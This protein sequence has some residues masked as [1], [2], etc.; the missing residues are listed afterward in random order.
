MS[1]SARLLLE[2]AG[3]RLPSPNGV[4]LAIMDLWEDERATVRQMAQLVQSDPGL[5]GRLL[6]LAN[7]AAM[8]GRS[9]AAIP[10][11]IVRVGMQTVGQLAV[12]FS[13]IDSHG[14]GFCASFKYQEYWSHCLLMA[15]LSRELAQAT[16]IGPPEDLFACG[17]LSRIG[18]LAFATIYPDE[19]GQLLSEKPDEL[20]EAERQRFGVDHNE[21]SEV[22]MLDYG[23]PQAL[24]EPARFHEAP[25]TSEFA[26][27]SRPAKLATLLH[28]AHRM[29]AI[30]VESGQDRTRQTILNK[31]LIAKLGLDEQAIGSLYDRATKEW[32][33]W[34]KLLDL[35][36]SEAP[37]YAELV[38]S[39]SDLDTTISAPAR[40]LAFI[41]DGQQ[42]PSGIAEHLRQLA[43][44]VS[45]CSDTNE[46]L[47]QVVGARPQILVIPADEEGRKLCRLIRSTD[48][49]RSPYIFMVSPGNE[50]QLVIE[51]FDTGA[52]ALISPNI[53]RT[54]LE[55]RLMAVRRVYG[56]E[57]AWRKDRAELRKIANELA[58][59]HRKQ[60]LLSLT[61]Q[62]TELP[63]RRA[64]MLALEQAWA[65]STR[66]KSPVSVVI[67]DVDHFKAIND[68]FGHATGD[69]VLQQVATVL[70]AAARQEETI[71]R[72]GG[73]EFLLISGNAGLREL[74]IAAER[75][76]RQIQSTPLKAND[77]SI[78]LTMSM[79]IAERETTTI[80]PDELLNAAD[81]ALYAAKSAGRNRLTLFQGGKLRTL[82]NSG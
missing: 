29:A 65:R 39:E 60:E 72:I 81:K 53:S 62:L 30:T 13:L 42:E 32:L 18:M 12:A 10:E 38:G 31:A 82:G 40:L 1:A 61:D 67:V 34:S 15:L 74:V 17:L 69:R 9:V 35:P 37:E 59:S 54:E 23:V 41:L 8:G 45:N 75:L 2:T 4:A 57:Q 36:Q 6:K 43:V 5:C 48:W 71:A 14:E 21:L 33:E 44:A 73:E 19:Y 63:N 28:C 52:D 51:A 20:A 16:R 25:E 3:E 64:A 24:A 79:G 70:K 56:L 78:H 27:D 26:T 11:A 49:G 76:R 55:A 66:T 77:E 7:S 80:S 46:L 50:E 68:R 47:R 22:L 58:V